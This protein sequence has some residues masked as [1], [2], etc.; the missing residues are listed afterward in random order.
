MEFG[1][2]QEGGQIVHF[3]V[4]P[5]EKNSGRGQFQLNTILSMKISFFLPNKSGNLPRRTISLLTKIRTNPRCKSLHI[6]LKSFYFSDNISNRIFFY[7]GSETCEWD[8]F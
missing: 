6:Y 4:N 3:S 7:L 5:Y 2:G 1:F 8:R